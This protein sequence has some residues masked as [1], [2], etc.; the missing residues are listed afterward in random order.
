MKELATGAK[1]PGVM[2]DDLLLVRRLLVPGGS[3]FA[4]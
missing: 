4:Y 1:R 3:T 2:G